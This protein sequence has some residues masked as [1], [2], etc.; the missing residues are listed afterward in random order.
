ML[1]RIAIR[2][3]LL[4]DELDLP[5]RK[6]FTAI[7]GET[8]SGKSILIGA[9]GLTMGERADSGVA[10][11]PHERC[12]IELEVDV[13]KLELEDWCA[14]VDVPFES[15]MILR[16]QIDTGGRSRAFVN[17]TPVLRPVTSRA[18]L[19]A[20]STQF[21]PVGPVNWSL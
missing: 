16:R 6:G 3:Y 21:V 20:A 10:R 9:L 11:D 19:S 8:G 15:P 17:D 5:V 2:N 12:V 1:R 13:R 14:R 7:T 4:I 18:S